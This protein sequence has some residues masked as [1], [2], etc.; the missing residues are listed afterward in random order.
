MAGRGPELR[1][2]SRVLNYNKIKIKYKGEMIMSN[3]MSMFAMMNP[4]QNVT[5]VLRGFEFPMILKDLLDKVDDN[6]SGKILDTDAVYSIDSIKSNNPLTIGIT[7]TTSYIDSAVVVDKI[8]KNVQKKDKG[9]SHIQITLGV[10]QV[11]N[12]TYVD[13]NVG[14]VQIPENLAIRKQVFDIEDSVVL[15]H[16]KDSIRINKNGKYPATLQILSLCYGEDD[17]QGEYAISNGLFMKMETSGV[18]R[19]FIKQHDKL[20]DLESNTVLDSEE[21]LRKYIPFCASPSNDRR[22]VLY[23]I[24]VTN[25]YEHA[26][27]ILNILTWGAYSLDLGKK[28]TYKKLAKLTTRWFQWM[29]PSV[30]LGTAECWAL[31]NGKFN[32]NRLDGM[33][34]AS[35]EAMAKHIEE[36]TK[37]RIDPRTL[38]GVFWQGRPVQM[39]AGLVNTKEKYIRAMINSLDPNPVVFGWD[40][41]TPE[42]IADIRGNKYEN[43]VIIFGEGTIEL[44]ADKNILKSDFNYAIHPEYTVLRFLKSSESNFSSTIFQKCIAKDPVRANVLATRL[45]SEHT[46]VKLNNMLNPK[47]KILEP[48]KFS[49]NFYMD[50][51]L[52]NVCPHYVM[53]DRNVAANVLE[54]DTKAINKALSRFKVGMKGRNAG[55]T[56]G[57]ENMFKLNSFLRDHEVFCHGLE[58]MLKKEDR[59]KDKWNAFMIKYPSM[60][61]DEYQVAKVISTSEMKKRIKEADISNDLKAMFIDYYCSLHDSVIVVP[62]CE[63]FKYMLA[64]SDFD[65]DQLACSIDEELVELL[66]HNPV[67]IVTRE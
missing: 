55:L 45:I 3:K 56:V 32:E 33:G 23:F 9:L 13:N 57:M 67:A 40:E 60:D 49:E 2:G 4:D 54:N 52:S 62:G 63:L 61:V 51:V 16:G 66:M 37:Y 38:D 30:S 18:Y 1:D 27:E 29:A 21:G 24:D 65:T 41:I 17:E 36:V 28:V 35:S 6:G 20:Y 7:S 53:M 5:V 59:P 50:E 44:F 64:G 42:V 46:A 34:W 25:G 15:R 12:K 26:N 43:K 11:N 14:F 39:K 31:Y 58:R 47:A 8:L 19:F 48:E 10:K 22:Y